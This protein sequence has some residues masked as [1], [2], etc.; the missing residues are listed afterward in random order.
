MPA[1]CVAK[2]AFFPSGRVPHD[3]FPAK[4]NTPKTLFWYHEEVA[5]GQVPLRLA[6]PGCLSFPPLAGGNRKFPVSQVLPSMEA[7]RWL[8]PF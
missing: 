5:A 1:A 4:N 3:L 2:K 8:L 6:E 7:L